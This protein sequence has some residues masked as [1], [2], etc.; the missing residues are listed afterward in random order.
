MAVDGQSRWLRH[1]AA[2]RSSR[3]RLN[4]VERRPFFA[5]I[6]ASSRAGCV[7]PRFETCVAPGSSWII[8]PAVCFSSPCPG[9]PGDDGAFRT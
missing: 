5:K 9:D 7:W 6:T 2:T 8:C 4:G 1:F 3:H